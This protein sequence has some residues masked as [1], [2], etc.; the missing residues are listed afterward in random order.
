M[1]RRLFLNPLCLQEVV[2]ICWKLC[3][4][5]PS[6]SS[7]QPSLLSRSLMKAQVLWHGSFPLADWPCCCAMWEGMGGD[8]HLHLKASSAL[9]RGPPGLLG[10]LGVSTRWLEHLHVEHPAGC[11]KTPK[12]KAFAWSPTHSP[13]SSES[14]APAALWT[15]NLD[16]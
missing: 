15:C 2:P 6:A 1:D 16:H 7:H 14:H 8:T 9:T 3:G 13:S 11:A 4:Q 12:E 5:G 10:L